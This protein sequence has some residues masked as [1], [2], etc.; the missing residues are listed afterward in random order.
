[1]ADDQEYRPLIVFTG[2]AP[3]AVGGLA[4]LLVIRGPGRSD[5]DWAALTV[6]AIAAFALLASTLHL[7]RPLRAFRAIT[8]ISTSWLSREVILFGGFVLLLAVYAVPIPVSPGL[9]QTVGV[10]ACGLGILAICATGQVYRL[11][12][13]PTWNHPRTMV[14]LLLGI[15]GAGLPL[16]GFLAAQDRGGAASLSS[17]ALVLAAVLSAQAAR[18]PANQNP[19][20]LEAWRIVVGPCRWMLA[21]RIAGAL[22]AAGLLMLPGWPA[23]A[24]WVPALVSELADRTVFF[25][26]GVPVS[27]TQRAGIVPF[28]PVQVVGPRP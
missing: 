18:R 21:L 17:L 16:G 3:V 27:V 4:G 1:M 10:L 19:E 5:P 14:S 28:E 26:S 2:L 11:A 24:A 12:S 15:I 25:N 8:R 23:L 13:R 22:I 20:A 9:R 7:G 6:L